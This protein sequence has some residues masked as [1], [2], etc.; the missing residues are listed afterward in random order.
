[1]NTHTLNFK[2]TFF[3]SKLYGAIEV[4]SLIRYKKIKFLMLPHYYFTCCPKKNKHNHFSILSKNLFHNRK[5]LSSYE[6][7]RR[8]Q[9]RKVGI[10][11]LFADSITTPLRCPVPAYFPCDFLTTELKFIHLMY[12]IVSPLTL[13]GGEVSAAENWKEK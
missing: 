11:T 6:R 1:V 4:V 3:I 9:S 2:T 12:L 10:V 7:N 13:T 5:Y 8:K